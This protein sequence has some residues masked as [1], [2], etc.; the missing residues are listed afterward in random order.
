MLRLNDGLSQG[1]ERQIAVEPAISIEVRGSNFLVSVRIGA[2]QAWLERPVRIFDEFLIE[3][4]QFSKPEFP[5]FRRTGENDIGE[6]FNLSPSCCIGIVLLQPRRP[7][8]GATRYGNKAVIAQPFII[9]EEFLD[10][11]QRR[12]ELIGSDPERRDVTGG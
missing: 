7:V 4:C 3:A 12:F 11:G 9:S 5:L 1:L 2:V 6:A 8:V 10:I